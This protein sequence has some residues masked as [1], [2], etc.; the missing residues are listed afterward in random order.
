MGSMERIVSIESPEFAKCVK[1]YILN[2]LP[3]SEGE[4]ELFK[5]TLAIMGLLDLFVPTETGSVYIKYGSVP[6]CDY[7]YVN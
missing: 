5:G 6:D 3:L 7:G 4:L 2:I 1:R